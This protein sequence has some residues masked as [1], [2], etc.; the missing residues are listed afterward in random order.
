MYLVNACVSNNR[1][2]EGGGGGDTFISTSFSVNEC[3]KHVTLN[4]HK[5]QQMKCPG[6]GDLP[7]EHLH[8]L[9]LA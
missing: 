6:D 5:Y 4:E 9:M 8:Q 7:T 3:L 1:T 2:I